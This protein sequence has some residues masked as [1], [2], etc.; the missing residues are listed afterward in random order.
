MTR[1]SGGRPRTAA[2]VGGGLLALV[3]ALSAVQEI[4]TPMVQ[5]RH[6]TPD[7]AP[8]FLTLR[9]CAYSYWTP[10]TSLTTVALTAGGVLLVLAAPALLVWA[11]PRPSR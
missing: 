3:P 5:L 2:L 8:G 7:P 4:T 9:G 10:T 6:L 1:T 11:S